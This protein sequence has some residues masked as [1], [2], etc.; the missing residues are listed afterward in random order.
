MSKNI[1]EVNRPEHEKP[2][3]LVSS[4]YSERPNHPS[5]KEENWR[6]NMLIHRWYSTRR[7][8]L[9]LLHPTRLDHGHHKRWVP[10]EMFQSHGWLMLDHFGSS[11]SRNLRV[12][13]HIEALLV[14]GALG[15]ARVNYI[16]HWKLW[17]SRMGMNLLDNPNHGFCQSLLSTVYARYPRPA[18]TTITKINWKATYIQAGFLLPSRRVLMRSGEFIQS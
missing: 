16:I 8:A 2:R 7:N 17:I 14:Q 10:T 5:S 11:L 4:R 1:S 13:N 12:C 18:I 3:L 15:F 6:W 9:T